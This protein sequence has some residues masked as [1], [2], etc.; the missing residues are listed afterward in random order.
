MT[1]T[2]VRVLYEL[3]QSSRADGA[4]AGAGLGLDEGYLSAGC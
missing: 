1:L 3:A 2:E 4:R